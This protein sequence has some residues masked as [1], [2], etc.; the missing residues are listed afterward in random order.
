MAD[1]P[2]NNA[3]IFPVLA[4]WLDSMGLGSLFT[5]NEQGQPGGWLWDKMQNG[6]DTIDELQAAIESTD[7]WRERFAVIVEQRKLAAAGQPVQVMSVNDVVNYERTAAQ[8]FRQAGLPASFYD[9]YRDFQKLMVDQVSPAELEQRVMGALNVVRNINPEIRQAFADFYGGSSDGWLAAYFLDTDKTMQ[10]VDRAARAAYTAG[11][12]RT[13]GL[14][15]S[16]STA[17]RVANGPAQQAGIDAGLQ[18]ASSM[19]NV[20]KETYG[21][22]TDISTNDLV[23]SSLFR[24]ARAQ[25]LIEGR[26]I[27]RKAIDR[28][29]TGGAAV[30]QSGVAGVR[31]S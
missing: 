10:Q 23:Q 12:G 5:V 25:R 27:A 20:A 29:S 19:A 8:V 9:S 13:Y 18:E 16:R 17:E 14:D 30:T 3:N 26:L 24:D 15:I 4:S 6:V 7:V 2:N 28:Q 21:E 31:G 11:M 1:Q 22:R